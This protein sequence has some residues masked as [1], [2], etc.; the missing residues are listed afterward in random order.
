MAD[1]RRVYSDEEFALVLRTAAELANRADQPAAS[2]SGL[3]LAEMK[4]AAA[5][6]GLDPALVERAARLVAVKT[7]ASPAE[8]L[9]GGSLRH[10]H[11]VRLPVALD[12]KTA[13]RLLSAIRINAGLAGTRD[14]GHSSALGMT[15]HDGGELESLRI[16]ARPEEGETVVT[17]TLDRRG[18]LGI[19]AMFTG[20]ALFLTTLFAI[21][22]LYPEYPALGIGGFIVMTGGTLAAARAF[23]ASTTQRV[24]QR[25]RG[26]MDAIERTL[27]PTSE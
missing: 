18:T 1:D 3:T 9:M 25:I 14:A 2:S 13:E 19:F 8:R 20:I 22:G 27:T 5:Q 4:S 10:E 11:E 7:A 26:A 23:W 17:V 21:F 16:T 24:Q 6:A 15:W 12:E